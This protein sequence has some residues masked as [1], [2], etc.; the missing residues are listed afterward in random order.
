MESVSIQIPAALFAKIYAALGEETSQAITDSL[1][2]LLVKHAPDSGPVLSG[3]PNPMYPRPGNGTITGRVWEIADRILAASGEVDREA[4]VKACMD[5][6][7]NIN[8]AS[9]QFSHWRKSLS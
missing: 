9:T 6:G 3:S 8:T 2:S 4:V 1:A 5:E 7:I